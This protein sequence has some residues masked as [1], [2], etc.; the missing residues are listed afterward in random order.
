MKLYADESGSITTINND[1][2]RYFVVSYVETAEPK[3]VS[4][5]F[6]NFKVNYI[7]H[8]PECGFSID[9]EIKG[10]E[11]PNQMKT[12]L[13]DEL[14]E[15]TDIKIHYIIF[16]NHNAEARLREKPSIS[17]NYL[18]SLKVQS[19]LWGKQKLDKLWLKFDNRNCAVYGMNSLQEYLEIEFCVKKRKC[20]NIAVKYHESHKKEIIQIADI[21]ANTLFKMCKYHDSSIS[22][23]QEHYNNNK[24][25]CDIL[26]KGSQEYFP[27]RKCTL[28]FVR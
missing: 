17:F 21:F 13:F 18:V 23:L 15:K 6:R 19:I 8:N 16:D 27:R 1:R 12:M 22:K 3:K 14:K 9:K 5:V 2:N 7:K 24:I 25:I 4:R 10:S 26:E 28:S 20:D 11:M